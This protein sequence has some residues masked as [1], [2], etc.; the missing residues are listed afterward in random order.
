MQNRAATLSELLS[1]TVAAH[2][3][4]IA[5][6]DDRVSL[7]WCAFAER[8]EGLAGQ[9]ETRGIGRGDR[10]AVWLPNSADYLALIFAIARRAAVAVHV[11]TRF[12]AAEVAT[13][14]RRA[15]PSLLVTDPGFAPVD[16]AAILGDVPPADR[17]SLR[18]V[19]VR[20]PT[21][22]FAGLPADLLAPGGEPPDTATPDAP[23][24][25]YTT[26]G[27][28]SGPKLV[29]HDQR[30]I[31]GH[32]QD[33]RDRLGTAAAGSTLLAAVPLCGTFG[34]A[35]A[36][37]ALAGGA[38]IVCVDR[39]DPDVCDALIRR[40]RVTHMV[41]G[42]DLLGR[43]AAAARMPHDTMRFFGF[44]AFHPTA[45]AAVVAATAAGLAPRAVYGS[46]ELQA[47]FAYAPDSNPLAAGGVPV[48]AAARFAI[49][50]PASGDELPDGVAGELCVRSPTQFL[51]YLDDPEATARATT[52]D[53]LFRTGD[54]AHRDGA[55]FVF[56]ARAGDALRL[57]GFLV[58]PEEIEGFLQTLPGVA[59][60]QVVGG[61]VD[62]ATRTVAFVR[63]AQG[64]V[65]D[66]AMLLRCCA[67]R[68]ARYKVPARI[69]A[70]DA[71]PITDSP[72]G[73]KIQRVR[74]REMAA[75]LLTAPAC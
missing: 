47:L 38:H 62:G 9:L 33:A 69:V 4:R 43:L 3:G 36:L 2:G 17:A 45:A 11:N 16:F 12:R 57:G 40:H 75:A 25:T 22:A 50:D 51:G 56:H 73:P 63:A 21:A 72:N 7:T 53:G 60:A 55:G 23:C 24:A 1:A 71:F 13:L 46:S 34:N 67:D 70:V 74:L 59:A 27:T 35:A 42:D 20:T 31:A 52:A 41:G 44:A 58:N 68:L 5:V 14:L 10:V 39:F 29:L 61:V 6:T 26:S 15:Q 37:A 30:A 28:T 49:R 48:N 19:L 65:F 64:A 54:L 32:A 8:V 18:Q 66:E